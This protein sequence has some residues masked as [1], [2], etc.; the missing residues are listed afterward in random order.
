[1]EVSCPACGEAE[2]LRGRR[3]DDQIVLTC[4]TCGQEWPRDLTPRCSQCG[5]E[6]LE[7][8]PLAILE[9]GRGTQLSIIGT[10]TI[11]LCYVCDTEALATFHKNRP[12]PLM[13]DELP[14]AESPGAE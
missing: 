6:D 13:P 11:Y 12:N 5:G 4:L 3:E 7:A 2:E 9:R 10:R 1:M 8:V 14:T